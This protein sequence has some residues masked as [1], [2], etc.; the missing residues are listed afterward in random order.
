MTDTS[1]LH[2]TTD[3]R[4][5]A[6]AWLKIVADKPEIAHDAGAMIGWFANAI[7]A[8]YD[9]AVRKYSPEYWRSIAVAL[10]ASR[11]DE[12]APVALLH[13]DATISVVVS[14]SGSATISPSIDS[15]AIGRDE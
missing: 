13:P 10:G 15:V 11:E 1:K 8:G 12:E 2:S 14:A 5:W 4:D 6:N 7:M 3:A 9:A